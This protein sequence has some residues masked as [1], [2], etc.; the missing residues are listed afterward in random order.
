MGAGGAT[1][2]GGRAMITI[3]QHCVNPGGRLTLQE[4]SPLSSSSYAR[5]TVS[6][7]R[8]AN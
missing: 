2:A 5:W 4:F 6:I 1:S 7:G 8:H 3:A